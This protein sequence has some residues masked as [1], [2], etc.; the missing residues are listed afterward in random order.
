MLTQITEGNLFHQP[1]ALQSW[2]TLKCLNHSA[3]VATP[4]AVSSKHCTQA[5]IQRW[6]GLWQIRFKIIQS[7]Y[8]PMLL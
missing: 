4:R 2:S 5:S 3:A 1:I 6:H 7:C 8:P